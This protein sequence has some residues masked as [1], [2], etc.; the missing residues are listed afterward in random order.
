MKNTTI[1]QG[2]VG[3]HAY[4]LAHE[5]S[6]IDRLGIFVTPSSDIAGLDWSTKDETESFSGVGID[7]FAAHEVR[8]FLRLALKSNPTVTELLWVDGYE[9]STWE[10]Q[11]VLD[12]RKEFLSHS[13]VKNAYFGYAKA[14]LDKFHLHDFK[15]K[16]AR[17]TLRLLRQGQAALKTG[18][19]VVKVDNPQEYFDL[20]DMS[21]G[22]IL[23][24]LGREFLL[25]TENH[26]PS[27][28]PEEPNK[29]AAR[30]ILTTI[31]NFHR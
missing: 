1:L 6:D 24:L 16:H 20:N 13:F 3:S 18:E 15:T 26:D 10:G 19:I 14:Q 23:D 8:K 22:A 12:S 9:V 4:G 31:R 30:D 21:S 17:H 7:D 25:Y 27:P 29:D 2:I 28:L 11:L 5:E